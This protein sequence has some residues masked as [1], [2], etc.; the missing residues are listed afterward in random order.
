LFPGISLPSPGVRRTFHHPGNVR[1]LEVK[2]YYFFFRS[3]I[4]RF[5]RAD[6]QEGQQTTGS[7]KRKKGAQR[8]GRGR[9]SYSTTGWPSGAGSRQ[10][11]PATSVGDRGWEA[12]GA[13]EGTKAGR[14]RGAAPTRRGMRRAWGSVT[15][16][17]GK[18]TWKAALEQRSPPP[19]RLT[20]PW[21]LRGRGARRTA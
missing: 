9:R 2:I 5:A 12:G 13:G 3:R 7:N 17:R 19:C 18:R 10:G 21:A 6:D 11:R 20:P 4:E 1:V 8:K 15:F 16:T 14:D